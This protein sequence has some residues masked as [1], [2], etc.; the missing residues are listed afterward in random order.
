MMLKRMFSKLPKGGSILLL[1][2]LFAASAGLRIGTSATQVM[3]AGGEEMQ[4]ELAM[5]EPAEPEK[6]ESPPKLAEDREG[7]AEIAR[8]LVKREEELIDRERRVE[9]R[10]EAMNIAKVEIEERLE[11]LKVAE[12]NLRST[13][14]LAQ[15]AAEDDIARLTTV[16]E[17]MKPKQ[18]A[19]VF[20]EM[21][22]EF[23]AGFLGRMRPD[24]AA[25]V[26]A[27]LTPKAAYSISAILAGRNANVPTE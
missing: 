25:K 23:A 3:A 1:T 6:E 17:N 24:A 14:A 7:Y 20:E 8:A 19:A 26:L 11:A 18:A 9:V 16:Y 21:D 4:Q 2:G 10:I 15:T 22:P 5:D 27:G 12:A 13:I